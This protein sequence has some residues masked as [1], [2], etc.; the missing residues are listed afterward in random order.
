MDCGE[1][2]RS[3]GTVPAQRMLSGRALRLGKPSVQL[4]T[5]SGTAV[6]AGCAALLAVLPRQ[7]GGPARLP[8]SSG[9]QIS[10]HTHFEVPQDNHQT[11]SL[12]WEEN[13][14]HR[15]CPEVSGCPDTAA[16]LCAGQGNPHKEHPHISCPTGLV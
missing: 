11:P 10:K 8:L 5:S 6:A 15:C 12:A 3:S 16:D 2:R 9:S 14:S 13:A 7:F 4:G 1:S